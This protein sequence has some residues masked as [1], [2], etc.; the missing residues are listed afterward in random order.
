[1]LAPQE[2]NAMQRV[3]CS[4][5]QAEL[6]TFMFKEGLNAENMKLENSSKPPKC[7]FRII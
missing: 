6:N 7:M 1:M 4:P 3:I 5:F 2:I